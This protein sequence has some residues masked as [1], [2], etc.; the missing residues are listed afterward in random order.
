MKRFWLW[1]PLGMFLM[2]FAIVAGGLITPA[3]TTVASRQIGKA[4][5]LFSLP[6]AVPDIPGLGSANF[7]QGQPR[8]LNIFASWCVPCIA[9]APQLMMLAKAGVPIDAIALRDKSADVARFLARNGNP[10]QRIGSDVDSR[11]PISLGSSGVPETFVIDGRGII[12]YQHIGDIRPEDVPILIT[13][14]N[15]ARNAQR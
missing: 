8:L 1:L 14:M 3:Q 5:P 2:F 9:E 13:A 11:V 6:P 12:R 4:L 15:A 10:Y 7:Q